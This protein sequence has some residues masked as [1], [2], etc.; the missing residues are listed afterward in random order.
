MAF[1]EADLRSVDRVA[2]AT[3]VHFARIR[4]QRSQ[5]TPLSPKWTL[6]YLPQLYNSYGTRPWQPAL[7]GLLVILGFAVAYQT[8]S[9]FVQ[10]ADAKVVLPREPTWLHSLMF[11]ADT[12]VPVL[13]ISGVRDWGWRTGAGWRWV[14]V[15]ERIAGAALTALATVSLV[16]YL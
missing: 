14:E 9:A 1:L 7:V 3:Q 16:T 10:D 15:A 5:W 11:T 2:D 6:S 13:T 12:F 8:G 4:V